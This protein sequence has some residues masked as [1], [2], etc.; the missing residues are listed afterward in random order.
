[1]PSTP[2]PLPPHSAQ[3]FGPHFT[4]LAGKGRSFFVKLAY[5]HHGILADHPKLVGD[6][7]RVFDILWVAPQ[8]RNCRHDG[9]RIPNN[10]IPKFIRYNESD[11]K[12][13]AIAVLNFDGVD[14]L[15]LAV[16][17]EKQLLFEATLGGSLE[18]AIDYIRL[19]APDLATDD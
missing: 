3:K 11:T 7:R 18:Q 10:F 19:R 6:M 12:G 13:C 2:N 8:F 4:L 1:M 5:T 17:S 9:S 14:H 16:S 15:S